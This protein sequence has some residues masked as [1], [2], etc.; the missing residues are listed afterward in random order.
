MTII[1]KRERQREKG[2]EGGKC[3]QGYRESATLV[4]C[5]W[6]MYNGVWPLQKTVWYFLKK[7][8]TIR[9]SESTS[10]CR[11]NRI[12]SRN[13]K[14]LHTHVH[15]IIPNSQKV[16]TSQVFTDQWNDNKICYTHT[17]KYHS[18]LKSKRILIHA[19]TW[20][21]LEDIMLSELSQS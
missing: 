4:H 10:G 21:N 9:S 17:T 8:V 2:R 18:A 15:S 7:P 5:W 20:M 3:W 19:T 12:E 6:E 11:P 13:S 16:D 1:K 14:Y